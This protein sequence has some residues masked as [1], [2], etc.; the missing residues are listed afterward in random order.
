MAENADQVSRRDMLGRVLRIGGLMAASGAAGAL[1]ASGHESETVWQIDPYKCIQCTKCATA[2]V[3]NPSAVK[4]QHNAEQLCGYC[5]LCFGYFKPLADNPFDESAETQLCPTGAI[6]RKHIEG[7]HYEYHI[8]TAKCIGCAKCVKGCTLDGNQSL[9][10]QIDHSLCL[11]CNRCAIA[12]ECPAQAI[13]RV[14]RS[15]P[16]ILKRSRARA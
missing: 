16:Y 9:F 7:E 3:L 5:K 15:S 11:D 8:N 12:A 1:I 4:C 13:S 2:C 10:L 14:P 6:D